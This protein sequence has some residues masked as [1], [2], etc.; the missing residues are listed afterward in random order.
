MKKKV[1]ILWLVAALFLMGFGTKFA[2][3]MRAKM[4]AALKAKATAMK[5]KLSNLFKKKPTYKVPTAK[6]ELSVAE[7]AL[8]Q[9]GGLGQVKT[10]GE[11]RQAV[12]T[13]VALVGAAQR[14]ELSEKLK[15]GMQQKRVSKALSSSTFAESLRSGMAAK[16]VVDAARIPDIS[17]IDKLRSQVDAFKKSGGNK[18][19]IKNLEDYVKRLDKKYDVVLT[20]RIR[21]LSDVRDK[22]N[23]EIINKAKAGSLKDDELVKLKEVARAGDK[24]AADLTYETAVARAKAVGQ[25]GVDL[26]MTKA[27]A[28]ESTDKFY[29]QSVTDFDKQLAK[30]TSKP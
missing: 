30:I 12:K 9:K 25:K 23:V 10:L 6:T 18:E 2:Y 7:K 28:R 1:N 5:T 17:K 22:G 29:Q 24:E 21:T 8:L 11:A 20:A 19:A 4:M 14:G 16:K 26:E 13:P 3:P 15:V 27:Q